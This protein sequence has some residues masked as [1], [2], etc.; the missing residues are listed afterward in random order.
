MRRRRHTRIGVTGLA[1]MAVLAAVAAL[2]PR[3][4]SGEVERPARADVPGPPA[5]AVADVQLGRSVGLDKR[6]VDPA[7]AFASD[8]TI[9]ASVVT[10]GEAAHVQLTARWT[11]G[12]RV[13]AEVSQGIAP[14]GTAVSE[15]NVWKPRGWPA[16]EYEVQVLVDD[17]PAAA[18]SFTVR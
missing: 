10:E 7:G 14:A 5:V 2:W 18:R 15:F 12:G 13:V 17:V 6:I 11:H 16:G 8:D 1:L 3:R 4:P 9:Y